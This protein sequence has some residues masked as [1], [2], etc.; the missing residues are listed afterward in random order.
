MN[1]SEVFGLR[2]LARFGFGNIVRLILALLWLGILVATVGVMRD[3]LLYPANFGSDTSNYV[4]AGERALS[5]ALYQLAPGDR[6]V[7]DELPPDWSA[8]ILSPPPIGTLW[9]ALA[10]TPDLVRFHA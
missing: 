10:W 6:P 4:A 1:P 5:G 7:P 9:A 2:I 8:P 3:D